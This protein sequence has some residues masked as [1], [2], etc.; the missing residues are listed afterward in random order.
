[1]C[2]DVVA[3]ENFIAAEN[4]AVAGNNTAAVA[5]VEDLISEAGVLCTHAP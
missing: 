5:S 2:T 4:L 3:L 1:V